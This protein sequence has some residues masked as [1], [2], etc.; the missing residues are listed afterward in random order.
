MRPVTKDAY[1]LFHDGVL[2]LSQV[3]SNGIC[4]DESHLDNSIRLVES[5]A[6]KLEKYLTNT[7]VWR[8]IKKIHGHKA[9]IGSGEQMANALIGMGFDWPER[10]Q[11]T[12]KPKTSE[13]VLEKIDHPY[14]RKWLRLEKL[15]NLKNTFLMGIRKETINGF[16]HP[17]FNLH[18]VTS[19]RSCVAEGSRVEVV[20]GNLGFRMEVPIENIK[21]GD[22]VICYDDKL[23]R[24]KS[25]VLWAGK[26]GEKEVISIVWAKDKTERTLGVTPGHNK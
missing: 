24:V 23:N 14:T 17:V 11:K 13:E 16:L 25:K 26:T 21:V 1:K 8:E 19:Y 18:L 4:I 7:K 3:E 2:T 12:R 5:K 9:T 15:K 6:A 22:E 20:F 10:T